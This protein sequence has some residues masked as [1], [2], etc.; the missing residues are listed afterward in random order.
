MEAEFKARWE[1]EQKEEAAR[2]ERAEEEQ[3]RIAAVEREERERKLER[4][5][6]AKAALEENPDALRKGKWPRC[7]Q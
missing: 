5:R 3:R 4:V 1:M 6:R 2:K 7:T